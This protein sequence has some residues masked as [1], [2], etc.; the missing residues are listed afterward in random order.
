MMKLPRNLVV[1]ER[2]GSRCCRVLVA[3][4]QAGARCRA[5]V[6]LQAVSKHGWEPCHNQATTIRL[7]GF[8]VRR[9]PGR[10]E[11]PQQSKK[12][13]DEQLVEVPIAR[14]EVVTAAL[15]VAHAH[16]LWNPHG[17][18]RLRPWVRH[19]FIRLLVREPWR[20]EALWTLVSLGGGFPLEWL[21]P[22]ERS[23]PAK[24]PPVAAGQEPLF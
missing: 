17:S 6:L 18:R 19:A 9:V 23:R 4:H 7:A 14:V 15:A 24:R 22:G 13:Q 3:K 10:V 11:P 16:A 8:E 1:C 21:P 20:A 12:E 2:C 5:K